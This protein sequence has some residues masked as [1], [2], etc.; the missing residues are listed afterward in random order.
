MA[1]AESPPPSIKVRGKNDYQWRVSKSVHR[2]AC[3][4]LTTRGRPAA[5]APFRRRGC[6]RAPTRTAADEK[7]NFP[8]GLSVAVG[9][10]IENRAVVQQN[11]SFVHCFSPACGRP[12]MAGGAQLGPINKFFLGK[13]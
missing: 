7:V 6:L 4:R 12:L 2:D 9:D 13:L 8:A 1:L 5:P 3:P 11:D 10:S